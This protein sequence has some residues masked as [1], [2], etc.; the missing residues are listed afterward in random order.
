[1]KP[2]P[3][4]TGV[5]IPAKIWESKQFTWKEKCFMAQVDALQTSK[6][7]CWAD[8]AYFAA[9]F[10]TTEQVIANLISKLKKLGFLKCKMEGE[11]RLIKIDL[12]PEES[13]SN[14]PTQ[15][16]IEVIEPITPVLSDDNIEVI[17]TTL[18]YIQESKLKTNSPDVAKTPSDKSSKLPLKSPPEKEPSE[19]KLFIETWTK[20]YR[21][22]FGTDYRFNGGRDAKAVKEIVHQFSVEKAMKV[23]K[24]SWEEFRK[25]TFG[26]HQ[27]LTIHGI[28]QQW[29]IYHV[30]AIG[31]VPQR[32]AQFV[33]GY[34]N[35]KEVT[36]EQHA[37]G[38]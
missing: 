38:W 28:W 3:R 7:W 20:E 5:F 30:Q 29:N 21:Q 4:F 35:R 16:N 34:S 36:D 32:Q 11:T 19:H 31:G 2:T 8:N 18:P 10:D 26:Y 22:F 1:M 23:V 25:G 15:D 27:S 12:N 17:Q 9:M 6:G 37:Q 14:F 13:E 33:N 24:R